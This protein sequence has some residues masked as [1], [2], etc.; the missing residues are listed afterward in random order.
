MLGCFV[1]SLRVLLHLQE[2]KKLLQLHVVRHHLANNWNVNLLH[3]LD[4]HFYLTKGLSVRERID[5]L[6]MHYRFEEYAFDGR[7][8][9][10]LYQAGG[11]LLWRR[12]VGYDHF[13]IT[14]T[15]SSPWTR[16]GELSI[17]LK[18]NETALH[19]L[20]F[21]WIEGSLLGLAQ[22]T[23][24]F[25]GRNQ[26]ASLNLH[27]NLAAFNNAFPNN[28]PNFFCF[29]AMQGVGQAASCKN[30]VAVKSSSNIFFNSK[31]SNFFNAYD[32]FWMEMGGVEIT[33]SKYLI[34][35]PF[36]LKPL[37]KVPSKHRKRAE[38]RRSFWK[39]ISSSSQEALRFYS[40]E[41]TEHC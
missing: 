22:G 34:P 13:S 9:A 15:L 16:E 40:M 7:Y 21:N 38:M 32:K 25:I 31:A 23:V 3:H 39:D 19:C 36:H 35:L 30:V 27:R 24:P 41:K 29:A 26:G 6:F 33:G 18:I 12:D 1:R 11:I 8:K 4:Q 20:S 37:E 2:H 10:K 17:C 28:S 14:L 5:Y